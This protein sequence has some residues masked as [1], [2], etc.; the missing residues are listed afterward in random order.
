[1]PADRAILRQAAQNLS[2]HAGTVPTKHA[3]GKFESTRSSR[4]CKEQSLA[5]KAQLE[6]DLHSH[7]ATSKR[8]PRSLPHHHAHRTCPMRRSQRHR[9]AADLPEPSHSHSHRPCP[10]TPMP[11]NAQIFDHAHS[12]T[13]SILVRTAFPRQ[14]AITPTTQAHPSRNP[15]RPPT[16]TEAELPVQISTLSSQC[17]CPFIRTR[18]HAHHGGEVLH[19]QRLDH[20]TTLQNTHERS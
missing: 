3:T 19:A 1:M 14:H 15:S 5:Q 10:P 20:Q 9:S 6:S 12:L 4:A 17:S 16:R 11:A 2:K 7:P 18:T 13:P 8:S